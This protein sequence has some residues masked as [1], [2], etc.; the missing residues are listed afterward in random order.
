M[1]RGKKVKQGK[2]IVNV[3]RG[4]SLLYKQMLR[5]DLTFSR[6][7]HLKIGLHCTEDRLCEFAGS[8]IFDLPKAVTGK[9]GLLSV[10]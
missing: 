5:E 9:G 2:G 8:F 10:C 1:L 3:V 4:K 6:K 7:C